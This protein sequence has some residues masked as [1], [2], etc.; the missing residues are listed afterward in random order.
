MLLNCR[1]WLSGLGTIHPWKET[2]ERDTKWNLENEHR[3]FEANK[4]QTYVRTCRNGPTRHQESGCKSCGKDTANYGP[5]HPLNGH[6]GVVPRLK[7]LS[8]APSPSTRSRKLPARSYGENDWN[9]GRQSAP[10]RS[11]LYIVDIWLHTLVSSRA[12]D[13]DTSQHLPPAE[14]HCECV[15]TEKLSH[16]SSRVIGVC[17]DWTIIWI[18]SIIYLYIMSSNQ[19]N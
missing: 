6:I 3:L 1:V 12:S 19:I 9:P 4:H 18:M 11:G 7:V 8:N 17:Y 10:L 15:V 2:T 16:G 5:R 13:K 14:S